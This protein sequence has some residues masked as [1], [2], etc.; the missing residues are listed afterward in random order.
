MG[1]SIND[2][3]K[4]IAQEL[5]NRNLFLNVYDK[6]IFKA[7]DQNSGDTG[8]ICQSLANKI[9]NELILVKNK[10]R[11]FMNDIAKEIETKLGETDIKSEINN[12]RIVTVSIPTVIEELEL[13]GLLKKSR[14]PISIG[15]SDISLPTPAKENIKGYFVHSNSS[16]NVSIEKMLANYTEEQLLELW[17]KYLSNVSSTNE[18]IKNLGFKVVDRIEE[19]LLLQTL[20]S[21]VIKENSE[22]NVKVEM[23]QLLQNEV[24]NFLSIA[25]EN[26]LINR[27]AGKLIMRL[28]GTVAYVDAELYNKFITEGNTPEVI[29]GFIVKGDSDLTASLY[30]N[31][32]ANKEEYLKL[33]NSKI[34]MS[35]FTEANNNIQR[36]KTVYDIVLTHL[37][38]DGIPNDLLPLAVDNYGDAKARLDQILGSYTT[39]QILDYNLV[40][41]DIVGEVIF[42]ETNFSHF[43]RSITSY[44]K[45][46]PN[47]TPQD[48]ATVA[49]LDFII[50]FLLQQVYVGD[51]HGEPSNQ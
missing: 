42:P 12:Y 32:I 43:A 44:S 50:D 7:M 37:Y 26:I 16:A 41:R 15:T 4:L 14:D 45:L 34:Q 29:L 49:S 18:N 27:N 35:S 10:L 30:N 21:N 40:A 13:L 28:E 9:N 17:D 38:Q 2:A 24:S 31:V 23:L 19:F 48:A 51:I 5:T 6:S 20:L 8:V 47:I 36:Y 46:N 39:D 25:K 11:P 3:L 22:D 1:N 33:W